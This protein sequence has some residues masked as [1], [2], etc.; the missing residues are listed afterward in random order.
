MKNDNFYTM[1]HD[2]ADFPTYTHETMITLNIFAS[3]QV[4]GIIDENPEHKKT[5]IK[6]N[7]KEVDVDSRYWLA[8]GQLGGHFRIYD[9]PNSY[10]LEYFFKLTIEEAELIVNNPYHVIG[11]CSPSGG[12]YFLGKSYS[13]DDL[14]KFIILKKKVD[15]DPNPP[16]LWKIG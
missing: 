16:K 4:L 1:S 6:W 10:T 9:G 13:I 7:F 8:D 12:L 15:N 5:L 2:E 11:I 14:K 3:F